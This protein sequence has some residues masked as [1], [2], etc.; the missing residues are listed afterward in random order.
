MLNELH[1]FTPANQLVG[2]T[3]YP[4]IIEQ[5]NGNG[6]FQGNLD[7]ENIRPIQKLAALLDFKSDAANDLLRI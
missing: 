4:A 3:G 5:D 6:T 7:L 1:T 2:L